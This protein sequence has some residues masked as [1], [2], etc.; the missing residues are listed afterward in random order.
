MSTNAYAGDFNVMPAYPRGYPSQKPS[1]TQEIRKPPLDPDA[2]VNELL[3]HEARI[4]KAVQSIQAQQETLLPIGK[5]VTLAQNPK[6]FAVM[7]A[8]SKLA[9]GPDAT[10][11]YG[12]EAVWFIAIIII[13]TLKIRKASTG[14]QGLW[15]QLY[16]TIV[17]II[18]GSLV[19]PYFFLSQADRKLILSFL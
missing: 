8:L 19:I 4:Q 17:Y 9:Q 6:T 10:T 12:V 3:A 16:M 5:I 7:G 15:I 14:L 13:R 18:G 11:F 1:V 2:E